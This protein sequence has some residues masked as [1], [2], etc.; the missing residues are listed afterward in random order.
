MLCAPDLS[1]PR[2]A[3]KVHTGMVGEVGEDTNWEMDADGFESS[4]GHWHRR[5]QA[6]PS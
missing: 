2:W 4:N 6:P 1:A 3:V 5:W